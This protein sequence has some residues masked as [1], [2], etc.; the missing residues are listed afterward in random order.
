VRPP[1]IAT[2]AKD[3]H[4]LRISHSAG[5]FGPYRLPLASSRARSAAIAVAK[6][7]WDE[8]R[9]L[10]SL[11]R[12]ESGFAIGHGPPELPVIGPPA[13]RLPAWWNWAVCDLSG[14]FDLEVV[15]GVREVRVHEV[16]EVLRHWLGNELYPHR[17]TR[18]HHKEL[19][20]DGLLAHDV[21]CIHSERGSAPSRPSSW[22][23]WSAR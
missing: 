21:M 11:D 14:S 8:C 16:R 12:F 4:P 1:C 5:K 7:A 22:A 17:R 13:A 18:H 9:L 6:V 19:N 15:D 20:C 3:S 23:S 2:F 10:R